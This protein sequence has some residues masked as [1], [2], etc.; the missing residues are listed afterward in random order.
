MYWIIVCM[1]IVA[2]SMVGFLTLGMGFE[3]DPPVRSISELLSEIAISPFLGLVYFAF[4]SYI[5][6]PYWS[7]VI[8]ASFV[9]NKYILKRPLKGMIIIFLLLLPIWYAAIYFAV[10]APHDEF[11]QL[12]FRAF[13]FV[14]SVN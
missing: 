6:L 5:F 8:L 1:T 10:Q 3:H 13:Q 4:V 11:V 14:W 12:H 7:L 9:L 2:V